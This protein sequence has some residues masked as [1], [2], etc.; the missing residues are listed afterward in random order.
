[1]KDLKTKYF[2][3]FFRVYVLANNESQLKYQTF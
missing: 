1:M 3:F 2:K